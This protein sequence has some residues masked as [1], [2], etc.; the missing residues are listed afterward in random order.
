MK[1]FNYYLQLSLIIAIIGCA[2]TVYGIFIS[3][4]LM[5]PLGVIQIATAVYNTIVFKE[6]NIRKAY[7]IYWGMVAIVAILFM[8][9]SNSI[10]INESYIIFALSLSF[11]AG[12]LHSYI[13]KIIKNLN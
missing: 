8:V 12:C 4:M 3:L 13:M 7:F 5:I 6:T 2:V 1:S 11:I 10:N 9:G